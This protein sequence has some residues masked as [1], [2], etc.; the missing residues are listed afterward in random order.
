MRGVVRPALWHRQPPPCY[1]PGMRTPQ[2]TAPRP[3]DRAGG[4]DARTAHYA[5]LVMVLL[6][7]AAGVAVD[8]CWEV[9][10]GLWWGLGVLALFG[11][12]AAFCWGRNALAAVA[13]LLAVSA[14]MGG[15]HR[16]GWA[17]YRVD[18]LGLSALRE[19]YPVCLEGIA[20]AAPQVLPERARDPMEAFSPGVRS[21][22][23]LE[24]TA[25]RDAVRWRPASG[26]TRLWVQGEIRGIAI[27]DRLR[28]FAQMESPEQATNP[29][30]FDYALHLRGS[31]TLVLLQAS[32]PECIVHLAGG[33]TSLLAKALDAM[34]QRT[35][36]ALRRHLRPQ[37][38][39][40]AVTMLLGTYSGLDRDQIEAFQAT[41]TVHLLAVSGL[42]LALLVG[43]IWYALRRLPLPRCVAAGAVATMTIG[44]TLLTETRAPVL[45]AAALMAVVLLAHLGRRQV[46]AWNA[47][48]AAGLVVLWV[49]PADLFQVGA[50]LSF[51][52]VGAMIHFAPVWAPR[53]PSE[54]EPLPI[55]LRDWAMLLLRPIARFFF[56]LALV[57]LVVWAVALPLVLARFHLLTPVAIAA[58][59]VVWLPAWLALMSGFAMATLGSLHPLLGE[60]IGWLCG[61]SFALLNRLV[62]AFQEIPMGHWWLPGPPS[63]W[64]AG[65]YGALAAMALWPRLRLARRW[66]FALLAGWLTAGFGA[67]LLGEARGE[68]RCTVLDVGH[69]CAAVVE[70]PDGRTLLYDAGRMGLPK[71]AVEAVSECLWSRGKLRLDGVV[72][73]HC[74]TDHFNA[75]P[76]LL[77]R[78]DVGAVYVSPFMFESGSPTGELLRRAIEE[79][80]VP[81]VEIRA[82]DRLA[83][84]DCRLEILHPPRQGIL[85]PDNV[86]SIVLLVEFAQRRL[87]LAGDL[88]PPGLQALLE[89]E[90][91][92]CDVLLSPHHGSRR[93]NAPELLAWC[94]PEWLLVS[95]AEG[96]SLAPDLAA[97]AATVLRTHD[98]GAICVRAVAAPRET[99]PGNLYVET[100]LVR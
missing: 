27:G 23:P 76:G 19:P 21:Q 80:G 99:R 45:R 94:R 13:V 60:P 73:S 55:L 38:A 29:G 51:L 71:P 14:G 97:P 6:S 7:A 11:W 9:A 79:A 64:L 82:G 41:G 24:V 69:G 70:L 8:R 1:T 26:Q 10:L 53:P 37:E 56:R 95:G 84:G 25:V 43:P 67:S 86:N 42:H 4:D 46:S 54:P 15:W 90:P 57:S 68:L 75:L 47:L 50:Q 89:E 2:N 35:Q 85:G 33:E 92:D 81:L 48:A 36:R 63:W 72:L 78:F 91:I 96:G 39:E 22:F 12:F 88:E 20:R 62:D 30:Q 66:K 16:A 87:L 77:E 18:E 32:S 65:F 28:I 59:P 5:P 44:Y 31:R 49:N 34:R 58:N 93:S 61:Q 74:D 40:T 83:G 100:F 98:C 3:A 52:A 17:Y